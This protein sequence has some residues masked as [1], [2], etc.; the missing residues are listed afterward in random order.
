MK[1]IGHQLR[2][3]AVVATFVA[4]AATAQQPP[5]VGAIYPVAP[6]RIGARSID[7]AVDVEGQAT[8]VAISAEGT[9]ASRGKFAAIPELVVDRDQ[10]SA[11]AYHA[12]LP[13][14]AEMPND[15]VLVVRAR[16]IGVDGARGAEQTVRFDAAAPALSFART[17]LAV[18][19]D[20]AGNLVVE[21]AYRGTV[22][23]AEASLLGVSARA[24][25]AAGGNLHQ[26]D[27]A[28]FV[29]ERNA[30]AR[31]RAATPGRL[32]FV[33]PTS[34]PVPFDGVVVAD[35]ALRDPFG[36]VV[37]ASSVEFTDAAAFDTLL[38]LD[39]APSS[40]LLANGFGQREPVGVE[41]T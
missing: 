15:G 4:G 27:A 10:A 24:L 5:S 23:A 14:S 1:R 7:V 16:A 32:A 19:V 36:R 6:L 29:V 26:A 28:A 3:L 33:V 2:R 30:V 11:V 38:S 31:A 20:P 9:S 37:H 12:L 41:L 40:L 25:R 21:V 35:V 17:P 13:F 8:Q 18:R 34:A 39:V 22:A